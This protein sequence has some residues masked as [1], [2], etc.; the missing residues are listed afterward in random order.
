MKIKYCP[1]CSSS[2]IVLHA[3]GYSCRTCGIKNFIVEDDTN[4]PKLK[5][6]YWMMGLIE[7]ALKSH[8]IATCFTIKGKARFRENKNRWNP[9]GQIRLTQDRLHEMWKE[10]DERVKKNLKKAGVA[11]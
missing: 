3:K 9:L 10:Y 5:L 8:E 1:N 4:A 2:N 6:E 7:E 11:K